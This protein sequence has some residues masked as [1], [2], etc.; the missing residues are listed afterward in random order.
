LITFFSWWLIAGDF[1]IALVNSVAVMVIACP[2]ALGLATP[3]AIMVG[4]GQGALAGILIRNAAALEQAGKIGVLVLDKTGTLTEGKPLVVDEVPGRLPEDPSLLQLAVTLEQGSIHPL[5]RAILERGR[6]KGV[7]P[8]E[9]SGFTDR[10]GK[11]VAAIIR[12]ERVM[13]GSPRLMEEEGMAW[14]GNLWKRATELQQEGKTV[15]VASRGREV[16]GLFGIMDP[17]KTNS[18]RAIEAMQNLN[19]RII[20]LTGDHPAAAGAIAGL[21]GIKEFRSEV[22]PDGKAREVLEI[23]KEGRLTGMVGDGINDAPALA[24]A[25]VSFAMGAGS[26][27]ALESADVTLMRND[28]MSVVDAIRLSRLT[29]AKIRQ[30][31][32]FAFIYNILGIPMAAAGMLN[33]VIA[34]AAMALSSVTVVTNSLL[35]RRWQPGSA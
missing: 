32:F 22:T 21:A 13:L 16:A 11:G 12:N 19:L 28:L 31:L 10:P 35:L 14:N 17:L 1:S 20:M 27:A 5:A 24:S 30:N 3:T 25:D 8:L 2:C 18:K 23:R 9:M 33:P 29:I 7:L 4:S 6:E 34:G 26:D 15:I